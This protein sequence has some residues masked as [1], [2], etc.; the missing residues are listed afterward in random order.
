MFNSLTKQMSVRAFWINVMYQ[1]VFFCNIRYQW[2]SSSN[3]PNEPIR[4]CEAWCKTIG[5][6][7]IVGSSWPWPVHHGYWTDTS[8]QES[9][10]KSDAPECNSNWENASLCSSSLLPLWQVEKAGW[11]LDQV[12]LFEINEAFAAQSIA[13]VKELGLSADK[14][15]ALLCNFCPICPKHKLDALCL[16][17]LESNVCFHFLRWMWA[18]VQFLWAIRS[19]CLAAECWWPCCIRF[20]GL[21][22]IKAWRLSAL[23]EGWA[24]PCAWRESDKKKNP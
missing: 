17:S 6:Y 19:V 10:E 1:A 3:C 7:R 21:G 9:G 18:V 16:S 5:K 13:V 22:D 24:S 4:G 14:V 12:D 2:W 15:T 23:E 8:H 11:Q 20:R